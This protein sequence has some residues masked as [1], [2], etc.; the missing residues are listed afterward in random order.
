M[1]CPHAAIRAKTYPA[2]G[3]ENA[4]AGF[5]SCDYKGH[6]FPGQKYTIQVAPEDCTG[7]GLCVMVCPA[8]DRSNPKHKAI[9]MQTMAPLRAAEVA[10]YAF[11]LDLHEPAPT[12]VNTN[13]LVASFRDPQDKSSE[14]CAGC[15]E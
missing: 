8:K 3:L 13:V 4:P 1:V 6:E 15:G 5:K 10:N 7:C 9:D 12:A 14:D 11:F 2:A